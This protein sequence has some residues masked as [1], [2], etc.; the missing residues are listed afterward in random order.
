MEEVDADDEEEDQLEEYRMR[1]LQRSLPARLLPQDKL[2]GDGHQ[3]GL[4]PQQHVLLGR[5]RRHVLLKDG[6]PSASSV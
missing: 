3:P 1:D 5:L 2:L 4:P 6:V